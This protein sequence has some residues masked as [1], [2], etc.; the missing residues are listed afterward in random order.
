[1]ARQSYPVFTGGEWLDA[2]SGDVFETQSNDSG[3]CGARIPRLCA[4]SVASSVS[5][6]RQATLSS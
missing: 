5:S 6:R 4:S 3:A 1:M 2:A